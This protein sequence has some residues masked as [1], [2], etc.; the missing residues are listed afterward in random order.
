MPVPVR[1][2][3][4]IIQGLVITSP[5]HNGVN[6]FSLQTAAALELGALND[7]PKR[8]CAFQDL[9]PQEAR[10]ASRAIDGKLRIFD[11]KDEGMSQQTINTY[12]HVITGALAACYN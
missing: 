6:F 11:I 10:A 5:L 2:P 1:I 3:W 12:F 9:D 4:P 7:L 8:A